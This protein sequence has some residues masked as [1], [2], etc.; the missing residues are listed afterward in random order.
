MEKRG[1]GAW[2]WPAPGA[3]PGSPAGDTRQRQPLLWPSAVLADVGWY[4]APPEGPWH[5]PAEVVLTL[6]MDEHLAA[7]QAC[8]HVAA[9][10]RCESHGPV[11][12]QM[13]LK[14]MQ[15]IGL[16]VAHQEHA[17]SALRPL[18]AQ[19]VGGRSGGAPA[20]RTYSNDVR[21]QAR[22]ARHT[23]FGPHSHARHTTA[24]ER[25]SAHRLHPRRRPGGTPAVLKPACG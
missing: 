10:R 21:R 23:W 9:L 11:P 5:V 25:H 14:S 3:A 18:P 24:P 22:C 16:S 2:A 12:R 19:L 4:Q 6:N 13:L 17:V 8:A 15:S 20:E 1:G 7:E